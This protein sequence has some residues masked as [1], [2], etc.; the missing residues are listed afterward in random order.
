ML[1]EVFLSHPGERSWEEEGCSVWLRSPFISRWRS[2]RGGG[3]GVAQ[4][5][6][7]PP[8]PRVWSARFLDQLTRAQL[9]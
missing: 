1:I 3:D 7:Q 5:G 9:F 8:L 6:H 4:G 2:L